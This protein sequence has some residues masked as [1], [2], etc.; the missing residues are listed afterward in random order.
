MSDFQ[1]GEIKVLVWSWYRTKI[2]QGYWCYCFSYGNWLVKSHASWA[3][4]QP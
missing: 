2:G 4:K 1:G 3:S